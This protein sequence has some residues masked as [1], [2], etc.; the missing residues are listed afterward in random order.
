[1]RERR[2]LYFTLSKIATTIVAL[3]FIF[4]LVR[5]LLKRALPLAGLPP[6]GEV[7]ARIDMVTKEEVDAVNEVIGMADERSDEVAAL[8]KVWLKEDK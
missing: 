3:V 2:D 6:E 4:L 7:G 8:L 5:Y 1:M